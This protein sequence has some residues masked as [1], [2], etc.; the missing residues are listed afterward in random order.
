[1]PGLPIPLM[2]PCAAIA[3]QLPGPLLAVVSGLSGGESEAVLAAMDLT[4]HL[5]A[6]FPDGAPGGVA[7]LPAPDL[8]A[9]QSRRPRQSPFDGRQLAI[10][11]P[12]AQRGSAT[13]RI[14]RAVL[15]ELK[16]RAKAV[17]ELRSADLDEDAAPWLSTTATTP[18][19]WT[20]TLTVN[21][22]AVTQA[23]CGSLAWAC[24]EQGL[25]SAALHIARPKSGERAALPDEL[26][27]E[28]LR[29][30]L[31]QALSDSSSSLETAAI[32][33]PVTAPQDGLWRPLARAGEDVPPGI[34]LGFLADPGED[35]PIP[36]AAAVPGRVLRIR[37]AGG[38][39][40]NDAVVLLAVSH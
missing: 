1:M 33:T 39:R 5:F 14:A 11:F 18:A 10:D 29:A 30:L 20:K 12:G 26:S 8:L 19:G 7:I 28:R 32:E 23:P 2:P 6:A 17:L 16:K 36:V 22:Q 27:P 38:A 40:A 4:T 9:V 34:P 21:D 13:R 24:A 3:G 25:P 15:G 37:R 31:A 35:R